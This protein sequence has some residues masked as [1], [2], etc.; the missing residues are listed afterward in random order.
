MGQQVHAYLDS[1]RPSSTQFLKVLRGFWKDD[2]TG[3]TRNLSYPDPLGVT[4]LELWTVSCVNFGQCHLLAQ[5]QL[6]VP[7][8][9]QAG[10]VRVSGDKRPLSSKYHRFMLF[11]DHGCVCKAAV[12][13]PTLSQAPSSLAEVTS[14]SIKGPLPFTFW[15]PEIKD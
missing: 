6:H 13:F 7:D 4:I 2:R 15:Q 10:P 5:Q 12:V 3:G 9:Q 14:R 8:P 1:L 11:A